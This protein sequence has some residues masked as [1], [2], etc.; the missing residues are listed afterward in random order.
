M[1]YFLSLH[2]PA[3]RGNAFIRDVSLRIAKWR[4]STRRLGGFWLGR[5]Q[6]LGSLDEQVEMFLTL[7]GYEIWESASASMTWQGLITQMELTAGDL[8]WKR[9]L[10]DVANH[11]RAIYSSI[12]NNQLTNGG[13]ESGVWAGYNS[14]TLVEQSTAWRTEGAYSI[15]INAGGASKGAYV[16]QNISIT[17]RT[18]YDMRLSVK[19]V[20]GLWMLVVARTDTGQA[21]TEMQTNEVGETVMRCSIPDIN[22][23]TGTVNIWIETI[24]GTGEIY[25]DA[26]VFQRGPMRA[27]SAI[28]ED[29]TSQSEFGKIETVLLKAGMT[30]AAA[31]SECQTYLQE[32]AWPRSLAPDDLSMRAALPIGRKA[33]DPQLLVVASGYW[34]TLNFRHSPITG[35][36]EASDHVTALVNAS[37]FISPG[38]IETNTMTFQIEQRAPVKVGDT[39]REIA[40]AGDAGGNKWGVGVYE[41]RR[42]EYTKIPEE[43]SYRYRDGKLWNAGGAE[44]EPW[45]VRPGW[46]YLDEAPIRQ[47]FA[48]DSVIDDPHWMYAEEVEFEAPDKVRFRRAR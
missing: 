4:R 12:G 33:R 23:Y 44:V 48:S 17:K 6:Y 5:G 7:L 3:L 37:E 24:G 16:Q 20:S 32:H 22:E 39:L 21:L 29:A 11:V 28:Y 10:L 42:L 9:S 35:T 43:L 47:A 1:N 30:T 36:D 40:E 14:P 13:G 45:L 38:L 41:N 46:I 27:E 15:H 2:A 19:L 25:C 31:N 18:P 26:G 34:S 8:V